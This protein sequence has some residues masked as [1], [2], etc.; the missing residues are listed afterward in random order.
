MI[1]LFL[2]SECSWLWH[3]KQGWSSLFHGLILCLGLEQ[4]HHRSPHREWGRGKGIHLVWSLLSLE[5]FSSYKCFRCSILMLRPHAQKH[6]INLNFLFVEPSRR[7]SVGW[8][9]IV[10]YLCRGIKTHSSMWRVSRSRRS[11]IFTRQT[12][13]LIYSPFTKTLRLHHQMRQAALG[14]LGGK[15][16]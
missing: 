12:K 16:G 3:G 4:G 10:F 7:K 1:S 13:A 8:L 5:P 6:S 15:Y 14:L 9:R 2:C 11:C